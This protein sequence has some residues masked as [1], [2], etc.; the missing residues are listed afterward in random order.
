MAGVRK[1]GRSTS[2]RLSL[3]NNLTTS[4]ILNGRVETTLAKARELKPIADS[5]ISLAIVER[6]N[7]E[8]KEKTISR[9]K[10][11]KNG[12][13]VKET[14]TS[15]NGNKYEVVVR[16]T[17]KENVNVDLPSRLSARKKMFT[18]VNKI[19]SSKGETIDLTKKLFD[20]IAP[21]YEIS[22]GG[23]TRMIKLVPRKGD[24][25][26]MAIVELI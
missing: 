7:F 9:A 8:V 3:L 26:E 5:I 14:K 10:L 18:M 21:K 25:A 24:G 1:L 12:K 15:K 19:K 6:D 4:L 20:E 13:I 16:E 17:V 23:Y 22:K 2:H 11:D